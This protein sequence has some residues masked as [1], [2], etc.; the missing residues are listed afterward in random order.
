MHCNHGGA[1]VTPTAPYS[2]KLIKSCCQFSS[3]CFTSGNARGMTRIRRRP[4]GGSASRAPP[5]HVVC[6]GN[7][8]RNSRSQMQANVVRPIGAAQ[9]GRCDLTFS[10]SD[11]RCFGQDFCVDPAFSISLM[12]L[13]RLIENQCISSTINGLKVKVLASTSYANTTLGTGHWAV[14]FAIISLRT[15]AGVRLDAYFI[16]PCS[17]LFSKRAKRAGRAVAGEGGH[18]VHTSALLTLSETVYLK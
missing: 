3:L 17:V 16:N 1:C 15:A 7:R 18:H 2:C 14:S 12:G 5:A 13:M 8:C 10:V 11:K 9:P 4:E 6:L